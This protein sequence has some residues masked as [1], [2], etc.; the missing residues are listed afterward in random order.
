MR[1]LPLRPPS[2]APGLQLL[3]YRGPPESP[4]RSRQSASAQSFLPPHPANKASSHSHQSPAP[5]HWTAPARL[6]SSV[7]HQ[8]SNCGC[9]SDYCTTGTGQCHCSDDRC[10]R[11]VRGYIQG[12]ICSGTSQK[13]SRRSGCRRR[14]C[15]CTRRGP[16]RLCHLAWVGSRA[17]RNS[18][19]RWG[20]RCR[21]GHTCALMGCGTHWLLNRW[22]GKKTRKKV[23]QI[24]YLRDLIMYI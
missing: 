9:S 24:N 22:S 11:R 4:C 2:P 18:S 8:L 6:N 17:G 23:R 3:I 7:T 10:V 12:R 20:C 19:S 14:G 1:F 15:R 13:C 5:P 16:R 21:A